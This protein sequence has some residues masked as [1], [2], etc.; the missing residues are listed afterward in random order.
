MSTKMTL[1]SKTILSVLIF[2]IIPV[3]GAAL[4]KTVLYQAPDECRWSGTSEVDI[5]L[6]CHLRTINSELEN[7]N[8]SVIQPQNTIRLR[9]ECNDALFF[10]S[11]LSPDSFRSLVELRALT[12]EYC[13][14][15]NITEGSF[16]GLQDLRNLT[17]R[18]HNGDWSTMSLDIASSS[19]SEFRQ[20]DRLD[21]SLN[22]I[23]LISDG[24]V[25][26]LK[27]LTHLNISHNEIQ[28]IGNFHFSASLST[29]KSR[30][31]GS[32]LTHLDLSA[33]KIANL[34]SAIFSGLGRLSNLNLARNS[35]NFIADR[36][37]EGLVSLSVVDLSGNRLTSL[38]PELFAEAK[39]V[40]EIYLKNNSIN[41]LAPGLF[42]DLADLLVLDMSANELNS[43]WV[44]AA[45]FVGLKRLVLLDLSANK[46]SKLEASIFRSLSSLQILKLEENYIDHI[47][48][49]AFADLANLHTLILSN[50]RISTIGPHTL[51][52][53][54]G[55]LVLSLDYNRIA[56]IDTQALRNCSSIQD[57]H[58]NGNKLQ[59]IPDAL[60]A[61]P[62]LKTLDIGENL[63]TNIENTSVSAMSNL[64]GLR[65]TE[66]AIEYIRR[67]VFDRMTS[68]QILNLSG[69]KI[70]SIEGGAL[71]RNTQ[72]QAI[73]LDGNHLKSIDGLFTEL[74]NLVWLNI[75]DNRLEKFDYS[76]IPTGLQWLDVRANRITQLGNYF[77]IEN[78][79]SLSTFDASSNMLSEI[80][81]SSIPN[82]V[83]VL[84]LN[85]NM[86]SK[87]QPY[88]FFKKPNLTRV[89]LIRN[90]LTTLE[91]NALR[92]SPI[93][94][95]K[96]IP[97]FYIGHNPFQCDCNLDWLQK[98]NTESRTQPQLMDLDQIYCKLS[99]AR[100]K[101]HVPLIEAK[102][103]EFLCKYEAHCFALCH[104][105]DFYACDCKM[106]CPD[107]CACYHD[108]SWTSNVV[109][110]SRSAYDRTLPSHIPMDATQLYLDGNNFRELSSHAFIGRKRLK[111]LHLNHSR[112]EI[113]HNRTFYGLLE[114][115]VLQLNH[116]N[117]RQ[118]NGN[119]F[120]GLDNL[121][122]LY[123]QH[124]AIASI[125]TLTFTHLYHL[126]ILRL[127]HNAITEFAVWNFLPSYLNELRLAGNP[128]S[129]NCDFIDKLRDY[130]NRHEAVQDKV[131]LRCSL[132][133][134]N[135]G[136][137]A[138]SNN[139][140]LLAQQPGPEQ[141]AIYLSGDPL[142]DAQTH[143]VACNGGL[144]APQQQSPLGAGQYNGGIGHGA[145]PNDNVIINGN[146]TSTKMILSQP[147]MHEYVPILV[148]I[149]TSFVFVIICTLLV[150][151]FRQEMRVWCHSRFG[152]RLFCNANRD[153][154][155]NEREKL[156]DAFISYSSKDEAFVCEDL[157][158]MLEQGDTRYKL[159]LHHRDFPVGG[160]MADAIVQAIDTSRRT[161]MVLSENFI[162][163]EWCRFEF[164]SA[165]QSV[166]RDRRRR[167]ILIVLGEVP[168]KDIDPELRLY[169]K[170]NTYLQWG[171][172][173]FWEKLRFALPDV[174]NN[175]RRMRNAGGGVAG[176]T[177]V[178]VHMPI[179]QLPPTHHHHQHHMLSAGGSSGV[180]SNIG[181]GS[182]HLHHMH[183]QAALQ[184]HQLQHASFRSQMHHNINGSR[185]NHNRNNS[186]AAAAQQQ[187][188]QQQA[189]MLMGAPGQC[190]QLPQQ[191]QQL[192]PTAPGV[193][194]QPSSIQQQ[195][196]PPPPCPSPRSITTQSSA[197]GG[198]SQ[199]SG[200]T[201]GVHI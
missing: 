148:A 154:D 69:N 197:T 171:D 3:L 149:L 135:N 1:I 128:W 174:P 185:Q 140:A 56:K 79:L 196:L 36:A 90:R 175:Q 45:T 200:R 31:C 54:Y 10:Q 11:S 74:P 13:K 163:S 138:G 62:L 64:Y 97:E 137:L 119:E 144:Q 14:L 145:D 143:F 96:D 153:I 4:S 41:V 94:D 146:M 169:L 2:V 178:G 70:K 60:S 83:E 127:D 165:H 122:E 180:G 29:R 49:G 24:M 98:V 18:T 141:L 116:N 33:N 158:P 198:S 129:C 182:H 151:I 65:L 71:H 93:P 184:H 6:V 95:D 20:L 126:K 77:E 66:N 194:A 38:P 73:R 15:G 132:L 5:T 114:L 17:I 40:K 43:Q 12:I 136:T 121:Q 112:I 120:Q 111:V 113:V 9:L 199:S 91:P 27:V 81:A 80:T 183:P 34:P 124:N 50:N 46:I 28:D 186:A 102:S 191:T 35:M 155:K 190:A 21:L 89:D 188:Q 67:G 84:Y 110:C 167:L 125:D 75:S 101:T 159:C 103:N 19:F 118:L 107:R 25:C 168:Q 133:T 16:R 23:W 193:G 152:I 201:M 61:V 47:P 51:R 108:Q 100:G 164:K 130:V 58:L 59:T 181:A 76:H 85:D 170:T 123:L 177:G 48:D 26:P 117:L 53:L 105:C 22:N 63:I 189:A 72:L 173:L 161:I 139:S 39:Y 147:P 68:L 82:S 30:I 87:I 99:Y 7:T 52:G 156:F 55:I 166:L 150:F 142:L 8:F 44:N 160:Y 131:K 176:C 42:S 37:F 88:T 195:Q 109:D 86:I 157:A 192:L 115:E 32:S 187:H 179:A 106:E 172:K 78:E 134:G 92:L 57:L 162:K 104:C